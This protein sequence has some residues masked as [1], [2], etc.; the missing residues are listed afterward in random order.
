MES[1]KIFFFTMINHLRDCLQSWL[2]GNEKGGRNMAYSIYIA[3]SDEHVLQMIQKTIK[4]LKLGFNVIGT[5]PDARK[6]IDEILSVKPD[7]L[8][9]EVENGGVYMMRILRKNGIENAFVAITPSKEFT[10]VHD[11]FSFGGFD[12]WP[13]PLSE[14]A[15]KETL[16]EY[17][18]KRRSG[19]ELVSI[20]AHYSPTVCKNRNGMI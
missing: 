17:E 20:R 7:V 16:T 19:E 2:Y 14:G 4:R 10:M 6:A 9:Y 3:H 12:Y 18:N 8:I 1:G 11:F 15:I 13:T 5:C